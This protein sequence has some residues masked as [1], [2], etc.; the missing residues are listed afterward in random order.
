MGPPGPPGPAGFRG[1]TGPKVGLS[2][3]DKL[4]FRNLVN[5]LR[6]SKGQWVTLEKVA[7]AEKKE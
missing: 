7:K 5:F 3:P 6:A 1:L 2:L 4:L